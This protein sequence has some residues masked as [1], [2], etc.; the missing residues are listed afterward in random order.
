MA[1][2]KSIAVMPLI[3]ALCCIGVIFI[4][5]EVNTGNIF[6]ALFTLAIL[7]ILLYFEIKQNIK[8]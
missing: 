7:S 2:N 3:I 4:N 6:A 1:K 8:L 5:P